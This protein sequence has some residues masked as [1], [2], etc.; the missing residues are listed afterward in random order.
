MN[1]EFFNI[2]NFFLVVL[3]TV[4]LPIVSDSEQMSF[5]FLCLEFCR[6]CCK[7]RILAVLEASL[8]SMI[9]HSSSTSSFLFCIVSSL[10][11]CQTG[12]ERA[13][14]RRYPPCLRIGGS[15]YHPLEQISS[16]SF[17]SFLLCPGV[18]QGQREPVS[19]DILH[20]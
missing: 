14:Q 20:V 4:L 17:A 11:W 18:R 5:F 15:P 8:P 2:F 10:S 12:S 16:F 7:A 9:A 3:P 19:V 6:K 1:A 13:S